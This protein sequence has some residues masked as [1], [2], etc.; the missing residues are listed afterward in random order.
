MDCIQKLKELTK[1]CEPCTWNGKIIE[2]ED[3]PEHEK[4]NYDYY[5]KEKDFLVYC[6]KC[7][8]FKILSTD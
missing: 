5:D 6:E 8:E 3:L 7:K 1:E 4:Y 2:F